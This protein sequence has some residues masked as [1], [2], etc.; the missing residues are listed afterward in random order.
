M[1]PRK[2][3]AIDGHLPSLGLSPSNPRMVTHQTKDGHPPEGVPVIKYGGKL[4]LL[5]LTSKKEVTTLVSI[6]MFG[7]AWSGLTP[8]GPVWTHLT[9][10]GP[11]F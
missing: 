4:P 8:F 10:F 6:Y 7:P 3:I 2:E 11:V 9:L 1:L 5:N